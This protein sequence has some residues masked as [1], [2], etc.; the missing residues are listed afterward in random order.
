MVE[1]PDTSKSAEI[2]KTKNEV[3][4]RKNKEDKQPSKIIIRR[5][6]GTMTEQS[7]LEH[8]SPLFEQ[9]YFYF[10]Q[11]ENHS[12]GEN[13]FSRAYINFV[14]VDD[15]FTFT[16]KFDDYVFLDDTGQ[17]FPAVVEFA[18]FQ[19]IPKNKS[20]RKTDSLCGTIEDDSDY[21]EFIRRLEFEEQEHKPNQ[22]TEYYFD[23]TNDENEEKITTTPLLEYLASRKNEWIKFKEEK[24]EDRRRRDLERRKI[25]EEKLRIKKE[26]KEAKAQLEKTTKLKEEKKRDIEGKV[27]E[28]SKPA[29][30]GRV[31]GK[32]YQEERQR[33]LDRRKHEENTFKINDTGESRNSIKTNNSQSLPEDMG[34]VKTDLI[35]KEKKTDCEEKID[36]D[37]KRKYE[38][39]KVYR[40]EKRYSYTR[41]REDRKSFPGSKKREYANGYEH[42]GK[43]KC[44]SYH[45]DDYKTRNHSSHVKNSYS[46]K[47]SGNKNSDYEEKVSKK[48]ESKKKYDAGDYKDMKKNYQWE[49][50]RRTSENKEAEKSN[51]ESKVTKK[52]EEMPKEEEKANRVKVAVNC[53]RTESILD[54]ENKPK[55]SRSADKKDDR[56][57]R[58]IKNKDRPALEIYRPGMGKFSRQ[59]LER[60]KSTD[61]KEGD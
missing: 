12:F 7:F 28:E 59:R 8:V 14:N 48:Y 51:V 2:A 37:F 16:S 30:S 55:E 17:E 50:E 46:N 43:H 19:R 9:D 36:T 21:Q 35:K 4:K 39:K 60:N 1:G 22:V 54:S 25:K 42:D 58:R 13:N 10:V 38:E 24:K 20:N 23:L 31:K 47:Y 49:K 44:D 53:K 41:E 33:D 61:S 3:P 57:E 18:P 26:N 27:V 32:S 56:A 5:L 6:P 52:E 15:V 40:D 45:Y 11:G 29:S 34:S